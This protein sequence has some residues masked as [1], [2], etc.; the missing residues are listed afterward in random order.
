MMGALGFCFATAAG[1]AQVWSWPVI[2]VAGGMCVSSVGAGIA[3]YNKGRY[4]EDVQSALKSNR[5]TGAEELR[6]FPPGGIASLKNFILD[7]AKKQ[8]AIAD[9]CD[10]KTKNEVYARLVKSE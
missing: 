10:E 1:V 5:T 9:G 8:T 7:S 6:P 3:I 2:G 4:N